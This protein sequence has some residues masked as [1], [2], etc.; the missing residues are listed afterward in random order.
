MAKINI[1]RTSEYNNRMRDYQI[2]IDNKKVG[3]I[4]NGENKDFEI[5]EG[6]HIIEAK[7]DWCGSPKVT[8]EIKTTVCRILNKSLML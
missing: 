7:I 6:T 3:T 8:I 2:Y 1:Q 5:E 4:E